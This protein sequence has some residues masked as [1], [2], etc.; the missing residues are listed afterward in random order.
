MGCKEN[1]AN[2]CHK[3]KEK[4]HL[5]G[6]DLLKYSNLR[7]RMKQSCYRPEVLTKTQQETIAKPRKT[8]IIRRNTSNRKY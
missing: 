2:K 3:N 7:L 6:P 4:Q 5:I 8:N 1:L